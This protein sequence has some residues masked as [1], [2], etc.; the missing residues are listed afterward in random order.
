MSGAVQTLT[1]EQLAR[2]LEA[3]G[4]RLAGLSFRAPL[5]T[6]AFFLA[7]RARQC[8]D[9]SHDPSGVPWAP[10]KNP[11]ARRGGPGAKPLRDTGMLMA[12]L[13]GQGS[14]HV[15]QV[16]DVALAWGTNVSYAGYHQEGT[17]RIPARP[18]LGITPEMESRI[19]E[20]ILDHVRR[21]LT[22]EQPG[23]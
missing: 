13:A 22:Q 6:T 9:E 10:L 19:V 8:F 12:S 21:A 2:V 7:S 14:G 20:I 23:G 16:S 5:K 11:S 4:A 18:F 15:E 1:F 17:G 3:Q